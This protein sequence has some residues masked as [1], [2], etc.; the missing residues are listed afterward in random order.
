MQGEDSTGNIETKR[1]REGPALTR[2][3]P[4]VLSLPSGH[5]GMSA[6]RQEAT[7]RCS[8]GLGGTCR[9]HHSRD[10]LTVG[11]RTGRDQVSPVRAPRRPC[12]PQEV[13]W[14]WDIEQ[15]GSG[16]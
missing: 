14:E 11:S 10:A 2:V 4:G 8:G 7:G 16:C 13:V 9:E 5:Q 6:V 1:W 12:S 3:A 15:V